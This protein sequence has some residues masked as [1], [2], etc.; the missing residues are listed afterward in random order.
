MP[1]L[2]EDKLQSITKM[3]DKNQFCKASLALSPPN[4]VVE[5]KVR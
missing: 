3:L 4:N 1:H 2:Q 5:V